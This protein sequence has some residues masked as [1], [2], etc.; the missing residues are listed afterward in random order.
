MIL[1]CERICIRANIQNQ[2]CA[3][4]D[5]KPQILGIIFVQTRA[6]AVRT[7]TISNINISFKNHIELITGVRDHVRNV[8]KDK[9]KLVPLLLVCE[10]EW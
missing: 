1:F 4:Y 6:P 10:C 2:K 7:K 8:Q 5:A 3:R 9:P